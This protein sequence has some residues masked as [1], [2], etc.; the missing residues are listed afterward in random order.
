MQE[1]A[2]VAFQSGLPHMDEALATAVTRY[3]FGGRW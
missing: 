3:L 1:S 2:R